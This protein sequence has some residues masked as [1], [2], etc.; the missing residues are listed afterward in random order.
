MKRDASN[1]SKNG[2][3]QHLRRTSNGLQHLHTASKMTPKKRSWKCDV[4]KKKLKS[5]S[6]LTQ[7]LEEFHDPL[8]I[9]G[10]PY[11]EYSTSRWRDLSK[12][13]LRHTQSDDGKVDNSLSNIGPINISFSDTHSYRM[14]RRKDAL[15]SKLQMKVFNTVKFNDKT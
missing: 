4:C 11:C 9:M 2:G 7:H 12:H 5:K 1:M 15:K 14:R 8:K 3:R 6:S 13:M 10:C